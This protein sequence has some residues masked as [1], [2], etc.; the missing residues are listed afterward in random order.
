MIAHR[1]SL[2]T[3]ADKLLVLKDGLV[4]RFGARQAV[5][6]ALN[7]PPIQLLRGPRPRKD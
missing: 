7:A 5:L 2:V 3:L 1:P 4:D 6:R